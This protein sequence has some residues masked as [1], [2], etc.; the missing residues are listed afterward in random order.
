[1]L[2]GHINTALKEY[3]G[4]PCEISL[5]A[6]VVLELWVAMDTTC[7]AL[8]PLLENHSPE[9]PIEFLEPLLLLQL[10]QMR[11]ASKI[12][13]YMRS[14][15]GKSERSYPLILSDPAPGSFAIRYFD[16]SQEHKSLR[17]CI[18]KHASRKVED[19]RREWIEK[20]NRYKGLID[21]ASKL[22]HEY[23]YSI[24]AGSSY[25][26]SC[27][28]CGLEQS[29][30]SMGIEIY[31]W[32][33]PENENALKNVIFEL[34]CPRW[35]TSWR[36]VTWKILHGLG[37]YK[38]TKA[39]NTEQNLLN[40]NEVRKFCVNQGQNLTLCSKTKSWINTHFSHLFFP[41]E[42][43][44]LCVPNGFQF[45]LL[46]S[47]NNVW[48]S[49]QKET[50]TLKPRC[51][52]S[53]PSGP[54]DSLQYTVDS[55]HHTENEVVA[56][57]RSCHLNVSLH[58]FLA[59]GCLRAG[60]RTQ[61]HNITCEIVAFALSMNEESV[62]ILFQ[63][64]AWELGSYNPKT[65]L[66]EAHQVFEDLACR[67]LLIKTLEMKLDTIESN[68]KEYHTLHTL[69]ILA[70]RV[71][72]LS[73]GFDIPRR[74]ASFLRKTRQVAM[75]WCQNLTEGLDLQTGADSEAQ[76]MLIFKIGGTCQLTFAV[77]SEHLPAV[78]HSREDLR[79]LTW[80]SM[81]VYDN[82]PKPLSK[83]PTK[84][85]AIARRT[86]KLLHYLEQRTRRLVVD[87][88]SGLNDAIMSIVPNI[89]ISPTWSFYSGSRARWATSKTF[90][91]SHARQLHLHYNLMTGEI[92]VNNCPPGRLP[93]EYTQNPLF[94]R[95][96]GS[97]SNGP[98]H[99]W[100]VLT[101][102]ANNQGCSLKPTWLNIY[103]ST[104]VREPSSQSFFY[105]IN[106]C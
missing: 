16:S 32:P 97:V 27:V 50:P 103:V 33:L 41:V 98:V 37:R 13:E 42:F 15:Y 53:I 105:L 20:S 86:W 67:D 28:R 80:S 73:D 75:T 76:A 7:I 101:S 2:R 96:F 93:A 81:I 24:R 29:A 84:S 43:K 25:L 19:K 59:F 74:V 83:L 91:T 68:W 57:Q 104:A 34:S 5:M 10:S 65:E 79:C 77:E 1:M 40:Y 71:L 63:Q 44:G 52:L 39:T 38:E 11:R 88:P 8:C 56:D 92:L 69:V 21:R 100:F 46:G 87:D 17:Y 36:D 106:S 12:E 22:S 94:K 70:L 90:A 64:A 31:E 55:F 6:L 72:S 9:I 62:S 60:E 102:P 58:E 35:F 66:R 48:V 18:E 95:V 99:I 61:W 30:N 82:T 89:Q 85:K 26:S 14:R 78:F 54:Y 23:G 4:C 45:K 3:E 47:V 49:D 51:T